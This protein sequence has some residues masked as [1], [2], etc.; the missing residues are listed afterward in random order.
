[1]LCIW[2]LLETKLAESRVQRAKAA[3]TNGKGKAGGEGKGGVRGTVGVEHV[4]IAVV[5]LLLLHTAFFGCGNVASISSVSPLP[6]FPTSHPL[7]PDETQFYLEPV[8][9]LIPIFSPFPMASLLLYK[10][11]IPFFALTSTTTLLATRLALPPF[12]L[13]IVAS[14]LA[15]VLTINFFLGVRDDL[16]SWLEIGSRISHF[17]ICSF[18][19]IFNSALFLLGEFLMARVS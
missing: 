1:M 5:F 7:T 4:R 17:A 8:F 11:L 13:I 15:D 18:L 14:I 19:G 6:P 10:L 2:L 9:R 12:A 3:S 16:G